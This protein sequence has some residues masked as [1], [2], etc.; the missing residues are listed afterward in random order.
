MDPET[1]EHLL[2]F[3]KMNGL[4]NDYVYV[5]A[6]K[7]PFLLT[8]NLPH[9]SIM[10]SN[11]NF[12]IGSDGL[13]L[14]CPP[15]TVESGPPSPPDFKM[16]MFNADGSEGE[17]CGNGIRCAVKFAVDRGIVGRRESP[18]QVET[19]NGVLEVR[20][21]MD[22]M[23]KVGLISV[24][25]GVPKLACKDIPAVDIQGI[26]KDQ[27]VIS[28]PIDLNCFGPQDWH[29]KAGV[30]PFMTLVS[31]GNP[32]V[33]FTCTGDL[34]DIPLSVIGPLIEHHYWFPSRINVHFVK[35]KPFNLDD[36]MSYC[37]MRTWERG[38]GETLACGTGACSVAVAG[39]LLGQVEY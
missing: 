30:Q 2:S 26:E 22:E 1:P 15:S 3:T 24:D 25:M 29:I 16:R 8:M 10:L 9:L 5:D 6:F 28:H 19:G 35:F 13:I 21:K 20:F 4:G 7:H 11:R 37:E 31:M 23:G 32:H 38:S 17:M 12:G 18:V 36:E 34:K 39:V 14:I 33:V 27:A